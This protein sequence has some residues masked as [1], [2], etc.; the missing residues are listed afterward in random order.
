ME[1][2][3]DGQSQNTVFIEKLVLKDEDIMKKLFENIKKDVIEQIS[4]SGI[5]LQQSCKNCADDA[6]VQKE[7]LVGKIQR[8][9]AEK[10]FNGL[11][12]KKYCCKL[13]SSS[14]FFL[15]HPNRLVIRGQSALYNWTM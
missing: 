7:I 8:G 14:Y 15:F 5:I 12:K 13:I 10:N 4:D 9:I 2:K 3:P 1:F 11:A 6:N